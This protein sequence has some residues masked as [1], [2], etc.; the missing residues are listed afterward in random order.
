MPV[1][2]CKKGQGEEQLPFFPWFQIIKIEEGKEGGDRGSFVSLS[3]QS[4]TYG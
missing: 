3:R 4:T 1:Q 2:R